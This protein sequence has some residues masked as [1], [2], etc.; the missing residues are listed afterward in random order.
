M[1]ADGGPKGFM[2]VFKKEVIGGKTHLHLWGIDYQSDFEVTRGKNTGLL[3]GAGQGGAYDKT[4]TYYLRHRARFTG[5][6][7]PGGMGFG[8]EVFIRAVPPGSTGDQRPQS[9]RAYLGDVSIFA[10]RL[11]IFTRAFEASSLDA[12]DAVGTYRA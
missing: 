6:F 11:L 7:E 2:P 1:T 8:E 12:D 3:G 5:A 9:R 4:D 10:G